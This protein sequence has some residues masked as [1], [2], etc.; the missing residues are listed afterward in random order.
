MKTNIILYV[1]DQESSAGF[2]EKVLGQK[3]VLNVPGM[4]EFKLNEGSSLGLM[5]VT[6]I[7]RLLGKKLPDPDRAKGIPR[8][9]LYLSVEDPDSYHQRSLENGA[10]EIQPLSAMGWGDEAAYS[11]DQDGHVLVFARKSNRP[12]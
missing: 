1:S 6:G 3:P 2:Y 12:S 9:E 11:I 8:A 7:K 4:T 5:P 10:R